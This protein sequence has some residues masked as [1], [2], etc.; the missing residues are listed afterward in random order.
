[1]AL[2]ILSY[3][4]NDSS[5]SNEMLFIIQE[6]TKSIDPVTY[7]NYKYVLDVYVDSVLVARLKATPDPTYSFG[8]FDVSVI[9]RDY[10]AA[11]ALKA[12]YA[13]PT[14]T[15]DVKLSYQVKLGEEYGDTLYTNLVTDSSRTTY[16]SYAP[17]PLLST[18]VITSRI[19]KAP[20]NMPESPKIMTAYKT[21]K[22]LLMPYIGN[23]S[24]ATVSVELNDGA[25]IVGGGTVDATYT[26][27]GKVMQ[28][29]IGFERIATALGLTDAEKSSV[30]Q[31]IVTNN[32]SNIYKYNYA[33]TK[34]TPVVLAWLNPYGAYESQSF[35]LVSKKR[36]EIARKEYAQ[37]PYNINA[38][39]EVTYDS[40]GVLYG[41][42]KTYSSTAKTSMA[43]TSHLLTDS[44]YTWLADLFNS[45]DVYMFDTVLDR[46][47][48]VSI[49]ENNYEYRTYLNS[50][51]TTLQLSINFTDEYNSQF[52]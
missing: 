44:E 52:L 24:G 15:Y 42:K 17:R 6:A 48:P 3:P 19:G 25:S 7:V 40:A 43:L 29:N 32:S 49:G 8:R 39:G 12:T 5:V 22:W 36:N 41:S 34:Q 26:D 16:K 35:G 31:M 33:C 37:L 27:T 10:V 23:V 51:L 38:S 4:G 47:V 21:D 46:F 14:E 50:K 20:S 28:V 1:M 45:T 9:L 18:A 11:Y 30:K 13:N 2:T